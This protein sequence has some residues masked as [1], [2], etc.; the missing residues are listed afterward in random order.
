MSL[1]GI[2]DPIVRAYFGQSDGNGE[3]GGAENVSVVTI[4]PYDAGLSSL[5][6]IIVNEGGEE[7][8]R[9]VRL[10]DYMDETALKEVCVIY[11]TYLVSKPEITVNKF[12][13]KDGT[14]IQPIDG[15]IGLIQQ[16]GF[17]FGMSIPESLAAEYY[18]VPSGLYVYGPAVVGQFITF[19]FGE[20]SVELWQ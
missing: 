17:E 8:R 13:T 18:G 9:Y 3:S 14:I 11:H 1:S 20:C 16:D 4:N 10:F 12:S 19:I 5:P 6:M 2:F 15:L 7:E